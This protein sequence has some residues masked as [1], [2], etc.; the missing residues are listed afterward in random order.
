MATLVVV[1]LLGQPTANPFSNYASSRSLCIGAVFN[2]ELFS[3]LTK[4][5]MAAVARTVYD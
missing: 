2:R 3:R 5:R 4:Q 1:W